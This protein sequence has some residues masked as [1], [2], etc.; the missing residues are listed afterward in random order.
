MKKRVPI[1]ILMVS[2]LLIGLTCLS[3]YGQKNKIS[4]SEELFPKETINKELEDDNIY[5]ELNNK[6]VS[7]INDYNDGKITEEEY[8]YI[9]EEVNKEIDSKIEL[10]ELKEAE[11]EYNEEY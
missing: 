2:L 11:E 3:T 9:C 1:I 6:L 4:T 7:A 10:K 8:L 5:V